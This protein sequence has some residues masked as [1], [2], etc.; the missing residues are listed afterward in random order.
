MDK[1]TPKCYKRCKTIMNTKAATDVGCKASQE[2][3]GSRQTKRESNYHNQWNTPLPIFIRS[4]INQDDESSAPWQNKPT[5][6]CS[7]PISASPRESEFKSWSFIVYKVSLYLLYQIQLSYT[8]PWAL[9]FPICN[10]L[11][12]LL[13]MCSTRTQADWLLSLFTVTSDMRASH[14]AWHIPYTR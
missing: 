13:A 11:L 8:L 1:L 14:G 5:V 3:D 4:S 10:I 9:L 12:K 7:S 2:T 6:L